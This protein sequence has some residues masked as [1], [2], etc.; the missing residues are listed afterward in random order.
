MQG[1]SQ[2]LLHACIRDDAAIAPLE[3]LRIQQL[4]RSA[5]CI[6][7]FS[8][9]LRHLVLPDLALPG[10]CWEL[11]AVVAT[12]KQLQVSA[13]RSLFL[14]HSLLGLANSDMQRPRSLGFVN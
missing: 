9:T 5:A 1:F 11:P 7:A 4:H 8:G 10:T 13:G 14:Q 6:M 3:V 2:P 12:L